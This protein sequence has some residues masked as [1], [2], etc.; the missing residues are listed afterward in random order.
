MTDRVQRLYERINNTKQYPI[1]VEKMQIVTEAYKKNDGWPMIIRRARAGAE[2]LDRKTIFIEADDP[3]A[4]NFACRPMG[5][6]L[7]TYSPA[8]PEDDLQDLLADGRLTLTEEDH[9]VLRGLDEYWLDK[10]RTQA[11]RQGFYYNDERLWPFIKRGYLC[12]P[13]TDR[14][15]GRGYG[16]AGMGWGIGSGATCLYCPDYGF[17]LSKGVGAVI[18]EAKQRLLDLRFYNAEAIKKANFYKA[19]LEIFPAMI[20]I[21]HRYADEAERLAGEEKDEAR[22]QELLTMAETCRWVPE[23][24]PRTFREALQFFFFYW[25]MVATGQAP[26]GRFDQYMY[27]YYKAD[28]EAGCIT[29]EE[30]L[31]LLECL[32]LK[33]MQFNFVGGGKNQRAKWAG[34]ARWHNFVIGGCDRDGKDATNDI[35]YLVLEAAKE[36]QTPQHTITIRVGKDTPRE[37]LIKGVEVVATG[38][39]MPAFVSEESYI[40]FLVNHGIAVEDAREFAIAGCLDLMLPGKSRN[41]AFGMSIIPLYLETALYNGHNPKTGELLGLETGEF[42]SFRSFEEFYQAF[43]KQCRYLVG[44]V[45]EEHNILLANQREIYPDVVISAFQYGGMESGLDS[46]DRKMPFENGSA[47]NVV[48][49]A[50]VADSLAAIKKLVFEDKVVSAETLLKAL[51]ANWEGYEDIQRLCKAAPKFGNGDAYVD[52]IA[53]RFW[54]D[55]ADIV[56]SYKS[57]F[58]SPV[59]PSGISITAHAPGGA[60]TS[61]S[62]DGRFDGE[63]FADGSVSPVHGRDRNGPLAVFRSGMALP[64][65]RFLATLLNMKISPA[66]LKTESDYEKLGSMIRTYLTHGGKHVQFNVVDRATLEKA[67]EDKESYR[68]LVVRVAG[69]SAYFVTL[70]PSVQKEIIART[71]HEI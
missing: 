65:Y 9:K 8:W 57:I 48:G 42:A 40:G 37:L 62:P 33:F 52:E 50:N 38:L 6:E 60:M 12:P 23:N 28:L 18:E 64:Q 19:C 49:M 34:M 30:A 29:R 24:P 67:V 32:R 11:E 22:R 45:T 71:T 46:L 35:S 16:T 54:G 17:I 39:G 1:C 10:G 2:Y 59:L 70:T 66:S 43:L 56:E 58:D 27:P 5:M 44:M 15:R 25:S 36:I 61:A 3:I 69:Y 41:H 53:G 55:F 51:Q 7:G 20:R 4:G 26:G 63:T 14:R 68:N 13:W 31:E 21:A 47:V